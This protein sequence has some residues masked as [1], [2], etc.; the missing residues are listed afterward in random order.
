MLMKSAAVSVRGEV[1]VGAELSGPG[2]RV[3]GMLLEAEIVG[4]GTDCSVPWLEGV[5]GPGVHPASRITNVAVQTD[6][7][8]R[9]NR[10]SF[11]TARPCEL[12]LGAML[13]NGCELSGPARL[14]SP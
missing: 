10:F 7:L 11:L 9:R 13:A 8:E 5:V 2:L 6:Q 12:A 3:G 1:G 14:L 4:D